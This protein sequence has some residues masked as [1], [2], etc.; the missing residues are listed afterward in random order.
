MLPRDL[1]AASFIL[2]GLTCFPK[3]G[4]LGE[5]TGED[6]KKIFISFSRCALSW[7]WS[8]LLGQRQGPGSFVIAAGPGL[9]ALVL[10]LSW[11]WS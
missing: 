10:Q 11:A 9:P 1:G 4:F 7:S 8:P 3:A 2:R 6:L 5:A